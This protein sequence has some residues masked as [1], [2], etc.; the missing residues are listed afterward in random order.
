M[1]D[2]DRGRWWETG[3]GAGGDRLGQGQV[4]T[5][6]DRGVQQAPVAHTGSAEIGTFLLWSQC[7]PSCHLFLWFCLWYGQ[8]FSCSFFV[9][10]FSMRISSCRADCGV[11]HNRFLSC[12]IAVTCLLF[13]ALFCHL[14]FLPH[15]P[16]CSDW[17]TSDILCIMALHSF[18]QFTTAKQTSLLKLILRAASM[19]TAFDSTEIRFMCY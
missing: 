11:V 7:S 8:G 6:W 10:V 12:F 4:V 3:T 16:S 14:Y 17:V 2:W 5:D 13:N 1:K 15:C 18:Y 9:C 19:L